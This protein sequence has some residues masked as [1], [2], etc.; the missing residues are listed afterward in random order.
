MK[1]KTSILIAMLLVPSSLLLGTRCASEGGGAKPGQTKPETVADLCEAPARY[2]DQV[3]RMTGAFNGFRVADCRFPEGAS[4]TALTRSDWLFRTGE[5]CLYVTGGAPA[6]IE[7]VD[8]GSIGRRLELTARVSRREDGR[9]FLRYLEG[10]L[11][12]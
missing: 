10:V 3:V 7:L 11:R 6:G 4:S 5:D 8:P 9:I 12:P 1:K 2:M